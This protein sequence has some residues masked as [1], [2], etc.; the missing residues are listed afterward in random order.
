MSLRMEKV[1]SQIRKIIVEI[2]QQEIDDPK[3]GL[4]S[5]TKVDTSADL[6]ESKIYFSVLED[7]S[8]K[9]NKI[10]NGMKSFIR[11]NLGKRIRLKLLPQL[12]FIPDDSIK[13]SVEIFKKIEEVRRAEKD[14]RDN[15]QQ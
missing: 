9:A 12:T 4:V 15:K 7:D 6:R 11:I 14:I 13:Y 1:N 8:S 10:L 2:I 5:I 3:L